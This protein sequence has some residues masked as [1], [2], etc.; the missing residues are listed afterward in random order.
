MIRT[1][2][3][4]V[5]LASIPLSADAQ[6]FTGKATPSATGRK[7]SAADLMLNPPSWLK[8]F[9]F[10]QTNFTFVRIQY[11]SSG[12]RGRGNGDW[13]TDYPDADLNLIQQLGSLTKLRISEEP[14]VMRL[15]DSAM[16][17]YPI[18]YLSEPGRLRLRDE[19]VDALRKYLNGGGFLFMDDFWGVAEWQNVQAEIK[20]V[21]PDRDPV[22]LP[23]SHRL[24]HCVFDLK[25]KPQVPS[26]HAFFAGRKSERNDALEA[27][28]RAIQDQ[29][30]RVCV[31]MCHNTDLGDGWERVNEDAAYAREMSA[32]KA[33]PMG[34]NILF[35]ALTQPK[36]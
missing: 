4:V 30:G 19:E 29:Q 25:A 27:H 12:L 6:R 3:I 33:Y 34:I 31:L 13:A 5:L 14:R 24:F 35:Y 10:P 32:A 20:R 22:D 11:D 36:Y 26:I 21:F 23:L 28:Y 16:A 7:S 1:L 8:T 2:L 9:D 18:L 17:N 15:T